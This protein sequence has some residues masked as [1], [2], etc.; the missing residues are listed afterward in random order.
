MYFAGISGGKKRLGYLNEFGATRLMLTYAEAKWYNAQMPRFKENNF[1]ILCD[2]GAFSLHNRGIDIDIFDYCDYLKKHNLSKY[3]VLDKIGDHPETMLNQK[4]MEDY[5]MTPIPVFHMGSP[6][7]DLYSIVD[8][9]YD[10]ICLGGTVGAHRNKRIDFF[11]SVFDSFPDHKFHGL[12]LSDFNIIMMFPF[13][14]VDSTTWLI[15]QK[16][17][18]IFD[19]N[20]DRISPPKGMVP[21]EKFRNTI[22][23]FL[24]AEKLTE[25][26]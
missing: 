22:S 21:K 6:L 20:G 25:T 18:K 24:N 1:D 7:K 16:V 17:G 2:S 15:A 3:I 14:S 26:H 8:M 5:G 11:N 12:G 10:Y 23:F 13:Y 4:I 19:N 9:G